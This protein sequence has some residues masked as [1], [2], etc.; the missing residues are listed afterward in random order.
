[1]GLRYCCRRIAMKKAASTLVL[2]F[3]LLG[4]ASA[5]DLLQNPDFETPPPGVPANSTGPFLLWQND[6]LPGWS[7]SGEVY[8]LTASGDGQRR[9]VQLGQDGTINQTFAASA[10]YADYLVTFAIASSGGANC[11]SNGSVV[12]S[13]PDSRGVFPVGEKQR[14]VYGQFLGSWGDREAIDLV[15]GSET[16][17]SDVNATCWPVV[18]SIVLKSITSLVKANDNE[19]V[20]GGFEFGP[21]FLADSNEGVLLQPAQ[22]P[23]Q[24][25]LR[26]WSILGTVKYIDSKHF[27]IPQGNAAVE[28]VSGNSSGIQTAAQL[29]K[30][31]SYTLEFMLGDGNDSCVGD[32]EVRAQAGSVL[33]N[34]T[35]QSKGMGSA[36]KFSFKFKADSDT[37][38]T[39][40]SFVSY[41]S[42]QTKDG[43]LCGPVVDDVVLR[44]SLGL[45]L[46]IQWRFL[47]SLLLFVAPVMN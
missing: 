11:S 24:S 7:F 41:V 33:Q 17:E 18:D 29:T 27:F 20:N 39:P 25:P 32:L 28:F 42:S 47:L 35:I 10:D 13:A 38:T 8:Y 15:I 9:A 12:I 34:Y 40:I 16:T 14:A 45:K 1:M 31:S 3:L 43:T 26:E 37:G 23:V 22:S 2:Q 5:A 4:F 30:D 19:L 44:A 46:A 6:T 36:Q 21:D